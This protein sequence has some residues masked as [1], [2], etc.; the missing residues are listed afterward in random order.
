AGR[1]GTAGDDRLVRLRVAP[2]AE[3]TF[4]E[5][6]RHGRR[7]DDRLPVGRRRGG[8]LVYLHD[9]TGGRPGSQ[10]PRAPSAALFRGPGPQG[11]HGPDDSYQRS[12][13][14]KIGI[15]T[16]RTR[17]VLAG[18]ALAA[19]SAIWAG[20]ASGDSP[21]ARAVKE[22]FVRQAGRIAS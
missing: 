3:A 11:R 2:P 22:Q 19:G 9:A 15:R 7:D 5:P 4:R 10:R 6:G 14:M 8:G 18:L 12:A 1:G 20:L 16:R 21:E 13:M 17:L